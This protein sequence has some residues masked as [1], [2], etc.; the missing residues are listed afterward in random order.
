MAKISIN[1]FVIRDRTLRFS[2]I[3][4]IYRIFLRAVPDFDVF[5]E[6]TCPRM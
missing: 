6:I 1:N 4:D 5:H 3:V 2:H